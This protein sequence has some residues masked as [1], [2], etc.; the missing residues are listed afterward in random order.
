MPTLTAADSPEVKLDASAGLIE[1]SLTRA[2][3]RQ[4]FESPG[5]TVVAIVELTS[6]TYTGHADTEDK[7]PQ[8]KV[9]V[10]GCE[11]APDAADEAAL[12]EAR[13][14]MYRRRRMDGTLDEVGSGP[15]GAASV[16]HDAFAAHPDENEFRAHQRAVEDRRRAEFV[17]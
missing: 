14:A 17:R 5:S 1:A 8:V 2:Q 16:V 11:V 15:Q 7:A 4:L 12:Q 10:T 13:R 9:R 3:R 6:V